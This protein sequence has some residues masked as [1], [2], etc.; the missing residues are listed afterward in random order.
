M[1]EV[2]DEIIQFENENTVLDFKSIQYEKS[3]Y[4]SLLKDLISMANAK[5]KDIKYII[6]GVKLKPDGKREFLGLTDDLIDDATYQQLVSNNIEPELHFIY[7][8]H[9]Y[10]KKTFGIFKIFNCHD[11][12]YMMKKDYFKLKVGESW[13]RKG[14]HQT[15]LTRKD[16]DFYIE[17][18][19]SINEFK[20]KVYTY[21]D[22]ID[23]YT[24]EMKITNSD[25]LPSK[26]AEKKIKN[27]LLKKREELKNTHKNLTPLFEFNHPGLGANTYEQ[28]SIETLE[29]NLSN[30]NQTYKEDDEHFYFELNANKFNF[31]ILNDSDEYLEDAS[32]ELKIEKDGIY[33]PKR[34]H[35]KPD[36]TID[37]L[38]FKKNYKS[39]DLIH[40]NYPNVSENQTE[41]II[42]ENIGD[43]KHKISQDVF[44]EDL[45]IAIQPRL[46]N[47]EIL[48]K[49]KIFGKN[50]KTPII[51][52]IVI[53]VKN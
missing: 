43:L 49:V 8:P 3:T 46:L 34:I 2:L 21:F 4:H 5:T 30:I 13:I 24:I 12:P 35:E 33:I 39:I 32:I 16:I 1:A 26:L 23:N 15:R 27:I 17:Q 29:E 40:F 45:R 11:Q 51:N 22:T 38:F 25:N 10:E 20:S 28:R 9:E 18:K 36:N 19:L 47:E 41:Y 7:Y 53:K 6:I 44:K 14:S 50:L 42:V 31:K 48:V 37:S 52:K